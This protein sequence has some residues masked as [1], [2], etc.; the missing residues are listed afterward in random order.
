MNG[1]FRARRALR[2][3]VGASL[4]GASLLVLQAPFEKPAYAQ[5]AQYPT[6]ETLDP[7][8][9]YA[10]REAKRL[11]DVPQTVTVITREE[12][13]RRMVRDIQ[14][15]VRYEPGVTVVEDDVVG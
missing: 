3:L 10:T 9:I 14:D 15:L 8:T 7:I 2:V 12:L 5:D 6:P 1:S 11:L 13:E 4:A